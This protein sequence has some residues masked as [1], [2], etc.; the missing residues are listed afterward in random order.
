NI[1]RLNEDEDNLVTLDSYMAVS[2]PV[3]GDYYVS[4]AGS[5]FPF[6]SVLSDPFD[7]STGFGVGSEGNYLLT[8]R[9][10]EGDPDWFTFEL[11]ACDILGVSLVGSGSQ[12]LLADGD[13]ELLAAASQD[14]SFTYPAASQ[15]PGGGEAVLSFVAPRAGTYSLRA[16]GGGGPGYTLELRLFRQV[17]ESAPT[18]KTL[19]VDFDGA[20]VDPAIFGGPAGAVALSPLSGFLGSWGLSPSDEDAL[21]DRI[22]EVVAENLALDPVAGPNPNFGFRLL[23]SRDHADPFGAADVSRLI[24]GGTIGELGIPTI[25]IA[26]SIDPGDFEAAETGVI[27]LDL[28][29]GSELDPNSLNGF[30]L[31]PGASK[32]ELVAQSVGNIVAHE[33]GH[34]LGNFHTEQLNPFASIM[35][36]G[37]NLPNTIGLGPDGIFGTADDEDVDLVEDM[38]ADT[39]GFAGHED[40]L[41][42]VACAGAYDALLLFTDGFESGG[43][44]SW[45]GTPP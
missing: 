12:V 9:L 16:L 11:E 43:T 1:V 40:T 8:I 31:A 39:E 42:V 18:P 10:E 38:F 30:P 7:A 37:G 26:Q 45:T 4:V 44:G 2:A 14:T 27:L 20:T 34:Y 21:I 19:F 32:L 13:G 29:S 17:A 24:V 5:L 23:N 35:D 33:A 22:L 36:R 3:D 41:A 28:L 15:L 6:A 25:G